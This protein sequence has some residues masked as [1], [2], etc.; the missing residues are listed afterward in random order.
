MPPVLGGTAMAVL[1]ASPQ[2]A[3]GGPAPTS[4][5]AAAASTS[6][7][8]AAAAAAAA[9]TQL[10]LLQ[11][12]HIQHQQHQA[13]I[14]AAAASQPT[15]PTFLYH[16]PYN[17]LLHPSSHHAAYLASLTAMH[18]VHR[19]LGPP[20]GPPPTTDAGAAPIPL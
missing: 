15:A 6:S 2:Q 16:Q 8:V 1:P 13:A 19:F 20:Y 7:A 5:T 12:Q 11:Q 17:H 14:L 10:N 4:S 3:Q 9:Q 18:P